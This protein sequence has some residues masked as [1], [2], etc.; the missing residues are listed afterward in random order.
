MKYS[1]YIASVLSAV[2]MA[3]LLTGCGLVDKIR[4]NVEEQVNAPDTVT[5]QTT[6]TDDSTAQTDTDTDPAPTP[7]TATTGDS[8]LDDMVGSWTCICTTYYSEYADGETYSSSA[9]LADEFSPDSRIIVRKD[10]D[11][12]IADYLCLNYETETRI[13][14]TELE[15]QDD[16]AY[17]DCPNQEWC[18][19]LDDPFRDMDS[20][21]RKLTLADD[22]LIEAEEYFH[23]AEDSEYDE[24]YYSV[25]THFYLPEDSP[26]LADP[27]SLR[28]FDTVTVSDATELLNSIQNNRKIILEEGTYDLTGVSVRKLDNPRISTESYEGYSIRNVSNLCL[29]AKDGAKVLICVDDPYFDVLSLY[30]CE[31]VTYKGLT[32]GH[33]VEP[34]TC[35]GSVLAINS[36]SYITV[37]DCH[38]YGC[39]TYGIESMYSYGIDVRNT[40]IYECTYGLLDLNGVNS[41][42]FA[43]CSFR[44]SEGLDMISL[45]NGSDVSFTDCEF[46][47]NRCTYN[48]CDFVSLEEYCSA[49]FTD[50]EFKNNEYYLFSNMEVSMENC[51]IDGVKKTTVTVDTLLSAD[52]VMAAYDKVRERDKEI[53]DMIYEGTADQSTQNQLCYEDYSNWDSLLNGIWGYLGETLNE[54]DMETLR[55]EQKK[56]IKEKETAM[57]DAAESF[58][59]GTMQ[60][61]VEYGTGARLT[62]ER[63]ELLI[64]KYLEE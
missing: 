51:T 56:W 25:T 35:S 14:G 17:R 42:S 63:V 22:M 38:L 2:L 28:Y 24:D 29:E 34:G 3:A 1:R 27:E 7:V 8:P 44:D 52:D 55:T 15:I 64:H 40:E 60:P 13:Y 45:Y 26:R 9:M 32:V 53:D 58:G 21:D 46:S 41:V 50:C 37:E 20:I 16:A 43:D 47:D 33:D 57:Q 48:G 6:D 23:K 10:A 61:Q 19:L 39:G 59:G 4:D 54:N 62:R 49:L 31:H 30:D 36:S 5:T 12:Y 11:R 18:A